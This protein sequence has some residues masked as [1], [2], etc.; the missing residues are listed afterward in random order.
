MS[1]GYQSSYDAGR[2]RA[3]ASEGPAPASQA[4]APQM[5]R[6]AIANRIGQF[7]CRKIGS[8][9]TEGKRPDRYP[10]RIIDPAYKMREGEAFLRR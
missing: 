5:Q 3:F 4:C 9:R 6:T 2:D 8:I 1:S 7:T 10:S